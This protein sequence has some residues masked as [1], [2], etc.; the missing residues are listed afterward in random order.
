[1]RRVGITERM[2]EF[3]AK[4]FKKILKCGKLCIPYLEALWYNAHKYQYNQKTAGSAGG[5]REELL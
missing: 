1:M 2:T 4:V 5:N 3:P